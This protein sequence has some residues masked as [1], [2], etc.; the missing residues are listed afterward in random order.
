MRPAEEP[1]RVFVECPYCGGEG[2]DGDPHYSRPCQ[3]CGGTGSIEEDAVLI[4]EDDLDEI[5]QRSARV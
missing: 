1:R 3:A 5:E 2:E 4:D